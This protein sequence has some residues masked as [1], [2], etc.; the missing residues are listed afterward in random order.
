MATINIQQGQTLGGLAS[1]QGTTVENLLSLNPQITNPDLIQA[2]ASLNVPD[3]PSP[4]A[5]TV[6]TVPTVI[7]TDDIRSRIGDAISNVENLLAQ[8]Q[9]QQ[10]PT[11]PS[12]EDRIIGEL[13][14][15]EEEQEDLFTNLQKQ[16][17]Q[18]QLGTIPL[19]NDE[20]A[21]LNALNQIFTDLAVEQRILNQQALGGQ[22][23]IEGREGRTRFAPELANQEIQ[24]VAQ[25]GLDKIEALS[26]RSAGALADAREAI[27]EKNFS[28]ILETNEALSTALKDRRGALLDLQK[29]I[30]DKQKEKR[31]A[32]QFEFDRAEQQVRVRK[33][34]AEIKKIEASGTAGTGGSTLTPIGRLQARNLSTQIFGKKAG[35]DP[36]NIGLIED[37]LASGETIDSIQDSLRFAGQSAAFTGSIRD[38]GESIALGLSGDKG[39]LFLDSLDRSLEEGNSIRIRELIQNQ[40]FNTL[41][42]EEAKKGRG[43]ARAVE[44]VQEIQADLKAFEDAGGNTNIFKGKSQNVAQK[45][46]KVGDADLARIANKIQL[47][48]Q[49]YR[50]A[51]SGAAF[52]ESEAKEYKEVFPSTS[53]T[54]ELNSALIGSLL[55]VLEGNVEF[56]VSSVI[57]SGAY[58]QIFNESPGSIEAPPVDTGGIFDAST[59]Q[60]ILETD[61]LSNV[62][63]F[64]QI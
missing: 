46:G 63:F 57:G 28:R 24:R 51:I 4:T 30:F 41:G 33:I 61:S 34:N 22:R 12:E 2:G 25:S 9:D 14:E 36:A 56:T 48:I 23:R 53:N 52:T 54:K 20:Q 55:D 8:Q 62:D 49:S 10:Q 44:L 27:K 39:E 37:L 17:K 26:I 45:I 58:N 18:F 50:K 35:S 1:L 60:F 5:P 32:Q 40:A 3:A 29:S 38:A 43:D 47:S 59:G 42:T 13:G 6:P 21:S 64:G 11:E 16:L 7:D 15:V 31:E 19:T